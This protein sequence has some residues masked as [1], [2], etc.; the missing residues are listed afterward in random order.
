MKKV[1]AQDHLDGMNRFLSRRTHNPSG[2]NF[3]KLPEERNQ[4]G[5]SFHCG[6]YSFG[7]CPKIN[8]A[9]LTQIIL[10]NLFENG[11]LLLWIHIKGKG[12]IIQRVG[13]LAVQRMMLRLPVP[14][15][16][17]NEIFFRILER[18]VVFIFHL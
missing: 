18:H 4:N 8:P 12:G 2:G 17:V 15:S 1:L 13:L 11:R 16:R 5:V 6:S 14:G 3:I 10:I 9:Q 7:Y